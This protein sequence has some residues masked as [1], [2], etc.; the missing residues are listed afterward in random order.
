[1]AYADGELSGVEREYV[2]RY[3]AANPPAWDLLS[4][5]E[6][7]GPGNFELWDSV[8]P[9]VPSDDDWNRTSQAI[10]VLMPQKRR[11]PKVVGASLAA[12]AVAVVMVVL[13]MPNAPREIT[14]LEQPKVVAPV[15]PLAE[16]AVLP[17]A[18]PDDVMVSAVRG[19][20]ASGLVSVRSPLSEALALATT[21]D[22][23]IDDAGSGEL[24]GGDAAMMIWPKK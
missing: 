13:L 24:A 22:V 1:M 23:E 19:N 5:L 11:W 21:E 12:C 4:D 15:D 7:V 14:K 6:E 16:F 10:A 18:T 20:A 9:P 8:E 2:E 3:L 17:I